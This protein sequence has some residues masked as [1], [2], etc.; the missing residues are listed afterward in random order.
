MKKSLQLVLAVTLLLCG[1]GLNAQ[2]T[3][4][5]SNTLTSYEQREVKKAPKNIK[6]PEVRTSNMRGAVLTQIINEYHFPYDLSDNGKHLAIQGFADYPSYYW[7]EETGVV[8]LDNGMAFSVSDDGVMAGYFTDYNEGEYGVN[9]AGRWYPDTKEWSFIGMNP[10][11]AGYADS[12]YN[13]AWAMTNDGQTL[14]IMQFN[15]SWDTYTYLWTEADGY[16]LLPHGT[17]TGSRPNAISNDARIVAGRGVGDAGWFVCYWV[18]GEYYDFNQEILGEAKAISPNNQYITGYTGN[19]IFLYDIEYDGYVEVENANPDASLNA[20]CVN[21][22]GEVFGFSV[23]GF[24]PFI[25]NR[26]AIA[27]VDGELITFNDYLLMNGVA[28][29]EDWL[30]YSVNTVSAD[31]KTFSGAANIDGANCTFILTIEEAEC[32]SPKELTYYIDKVNNYDDI[33]LSWTA[34]QEAADLT[35]EIYDSYTADEPLVSGITETTYTFE[36]MLPGNY[37]F[38]VKAKW[39]DGCLSPGTNIVRPTVDPCSS[40]DQC[41]V[42]VVAYD[43][44]GDGWN[45][46]YI[47]VAGEESGM[48]YKMELRNGFSDTLRLSLCP[49]VYTFKWVAGYYDE[50][51]SFTIHAN[52]ELLYDS[53]PVGIPEAGTILK[54]ELNCANEEIVEL[55]PFVKIADEYTFPYDISDNKK[56]VIMQTFAEGLSYYWSE[57]TGLIEILGYAHAVSDDGVVAC[58]YLDETSWVYLAGLWLPSTQEWTPL[59]EIPG[60]EVPTEGTYDMPSDYSGA[61]SMTNDGNTIAVMYTD[62]AWNTESYLYT[63]TD[64]YVKLDA[65]SSSRPNAISNDARVIAGHGVADLGWTICYWVDGEYHEVPNI[66]GEALAVSSSGKYVGGTIDS[67]AAFV[68]DTDT[69]EILTI[70][71]ND[72]MI[73]S[74]TTACLNNDGTAFGFYSNAF[75]P[76]PSSR[77]AFVYIS[78]SLISFNDYLADNGYEGAEDWYFYSVSAVTSDGRTFLCAANID[79]KDCSAI[80]TIPEAECGAPSNLTYTI[81]E[82]NYNNVVLSWTAPE[83]PVDVTY[84]IYENYLS[85]TPIVTAVTE[86][87][88]TVEGLEPGIHSFVVRANWN[89][90]CLSMPSNVVKPTIYPCASEDMCELTFIMTDEYGDG[91]NEGYIEIVGTKSDL[92]YKVMIDN[93]KLQETKTLSLCSDTYTITWVSGQW[94]GEIAFAILN[95]EDELYSVKFADL[96]DM[97]IGT[98][99]EYNLDCTI[100]VGEI[101]SHNGI[102]VMPNPAKDYFNIEGMMMTTVEV[103]NTVG[104][105]IDVVNVN[106]DNIQISTA[107]YEEGVY[108]VK[109]NTTE[110]NTVVKKV[111]ITK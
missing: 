45:E 25:E 102:N 54:Q 10:D 66:Y 39:S 80:I 9:F 1:Y 74:F 46:G 108:F 15:E 81:D 50:E 16:T 23:E 95:G 20:T 103:F 71:G 56:H 92:V 43:V 30:I 17:A 78:G 86:T 77:E 100:G 89:N 104:Q 33:V 35:Y 70:T 99:L 49:D 60:K 5:K 58:Y 82:E 27:F 106:N 64:G 85:E 40:A 36:D 37:S 57:E 13:G 61:W 96:E 98:F 69:D 51:I 24:P 19:T 47:E 93:G 76:T 87:S 7:S 75:P 79:G 6:T 34:P 22:D 4:M 3:D 110:A 90:E 2:R 52:D 8:S 44:Y 11:V 32:E 21:N 68:V 18:D 48:T 72:E 84:E 101:V 94:D 28:E 111:V 88:Y 55:P 29:A 63:E 62:P 83:N 67:G 105:M 73:G 42:Y 12:E 26:R 107:K 38:V 109:I 14:A 65:T 41:E 91:W 97:I 53:T 31:G 59:A